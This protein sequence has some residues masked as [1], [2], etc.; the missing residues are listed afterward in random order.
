M[1]DYY[2]YMITNKRN[3]VLY[4]GVT[5]NLTRRMYEHKEKLI[6]GFSEK[7]NCNKL[8]WYEHTNSIESAIVKEKQMEI[9]KREYK[10]NVINGMNP[11]WKDLSEELY[12]IPAFAGMT[13]KNVKK[14]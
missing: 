5:N 13:D 10:E 11:Q 7:Y 6:A 8:V 12:E 4:I 1:N 14:E 9:W 3:T 2:V